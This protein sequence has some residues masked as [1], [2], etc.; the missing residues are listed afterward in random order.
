MNFIFTLLVGVATA[1]DTPPI[2]LETD[3]DAWLS[4]DQTSGFNVDADGTQGGQ[5]THV[6]GRQIVGLALKGKSI[7]IHTAVG[8]TEY[9]IDGNPWAIPGDIDERN[10]HASLWA[11][12]ARRLSVQSNLAGAQVEAGLVT[13]HWGLG[14]MANDGAHDP[15]FGLPEFGDRMLRARL[16]T[17]PSETSPWFFTGAM[18][19]VLQDD[20]TVDPRR[21]WTQ[22]GI[23]SALWKQDDDSW[24][25][26]GVS[27]RQDELDVSRS[28]RAGVLDAF[29]D[30]TLDVHENT[31]LRVA[32]EAAGISG[33]TNRATAYNSRQRVHIRSGGA[34]ALAML[35]NQWLGIGSSSG[36][37]SG[38]GD[39]ADDQMNDFTFDRNF[40]VGMV[41]FDEVMGGIE[42]A[43]YRHLID[44]AYAGSPPDGVEASV[45]EGSFRRASYLQPRIELDP[46]P[47]IHARGGLLMAWAT[48][49]INQPFY[50]H[51]NGGVPVNHLKKT[52]SGYGLGTE[53]D[54]AVQLTPYENKIREAATYAPSISVQGG[55]AWLSDNLGGGQVD[56]YILMV[57]VD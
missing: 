49:P 55:H 4:A 11:V 54:W 28:T 34:T 42:A 30:F 52:T 16:T 23:L 7:A 29:G 5:G 46:H 51:R 57:R 56:R 19:R 32:F 14:M 26:Y 18:D 35:H 12:Q 24:G 21:Q 39:P 20:L 37:A 6:G 1:A 33:K 47:W 31:T 50:T 10:R 27:R 48:A 41:L 22:Q 43:T 40:G 17:K 36:I 8:F 13:S 44:P 3:L 9:Q 45:T 53:F 2:S 15:Y 25:V 38:D